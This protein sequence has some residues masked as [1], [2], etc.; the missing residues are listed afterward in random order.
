MSKRPLTNG[1]DVKMPVGQW[2][3]WQ[4]CFTWVESGAHLRKLSRSCTCCVW[5]YRPSGINVLGSQ[6]PSPGNKSRSCSDPDSPQNST[7]TSQLYPHLTTLPTPHNSTHTSQ[8]YPHLTTLPTPQN[9]THTSQLYP[10]LKTL[11]T[12]HLEPRKLGSFP[13]AEVSKRLL[14]PSCT[15]IRFS[16]TSAPAVW[17]FWRHTVNS[18]GDCPIAHWRVPRQ[19]RI[20]TSGTSIMR[21]GKR[22]R[23]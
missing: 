21:D 13:V 2:N 14:A 18:F 1:S 11:P 23:S 16:N 6:R 20:I 12:P 3:W 7:H 5:L 10:H 4:L 17:G 22:A 15:S 8:L 9:S 19:I